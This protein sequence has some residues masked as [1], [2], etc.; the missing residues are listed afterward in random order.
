[1]KTIQVP[2]NDVKELAQLKVGDKV[3]LT[4]TIITARDQ[5]HKKLVE[6]I[7]KGK[8]LPV[9]LKGQVIYY[10]GPSPA[11]PGK[12]IGAAGPT[13]ASRMD[14]FAPA[15][16]KAGVKITIGKGYRDQTV[17][18]SCKANQSIYLVA[19]GGAGA[20]LSKHIKSAKIV[21]YG[22]LGTEA[23]RELEISNF[24]AVVAIDTKGHYIFEVKK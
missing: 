15:L 3:L 20:L 11:R 1:M 7:K 10:V 13:T 19:T 24:P 12:V 9:N 16:Y 21:A 17:I 8:K 18:K 23:I 22:E 2:I 4:G 6:T 5:A 14:G